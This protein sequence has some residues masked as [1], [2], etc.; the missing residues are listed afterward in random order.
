[1]SDAGLRWDGEGDSVRGCGGF[2]FAPIVVLRHGH[3]L[4]SSYEAMV[5]V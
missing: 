3:S 2:S 5:L 4:F 1:M